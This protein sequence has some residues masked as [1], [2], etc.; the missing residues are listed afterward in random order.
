MLKDTYTASAQIA[1]NRHE[2]HAGM[3]VSRTPIMRLPHFTP[4][5]T[6]LF[7]HNLPNLCVPMHGVHLNRFFM[8][9]VHAV[10]GGC[11]QLGYDCLSAF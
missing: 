7:V 8:P 10:P 6:N 1:L 4:A 3:R 2:Y 9:A 11:V 5:C